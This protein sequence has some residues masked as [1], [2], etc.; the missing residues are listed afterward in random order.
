MDDRTDDRVHD[1]VVVGAGF[2][3][4][5][6]AIQLRRLGYDDLV[7]LERE[8]GLG[9]TWHVNRYPGL[10]VD[11]PS[12]TYCY[13]FEPN[14]SWS[15]LFAPGPELKAS[16]STSRRSTTCTGTYGSASP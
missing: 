9:G 15:R 14:P 7:V 10:A 5:G 1:A 6:A 13:S 11:I 2:G 4:I 8:D 12:A 16:P 3:G